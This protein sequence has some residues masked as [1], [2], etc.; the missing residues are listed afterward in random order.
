MNRGLPEDLN[1]AFP[2]IIPVT[3]PL[4]NN[5]IIQ[6]LNWLVGFVEGEGCFFVDI[7]KSNRYGVGSQ[8]QLKFSTGQHTRDIKLMNSLIN[9]LDCGRLA[10]HSKNPVVEYVV[11][12]LSDI[13]K[14]IIPLFDK[15][16][17]H[18]TKALNYKDFCK[19][20]DLIKNKAHLTASGLDQIGQ[21]KAGMN[22]RRNHL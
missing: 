21:I 17:L 16:P 11:T 15:Y 10:I 22:K 20:S 3:R 4:V 9:F 7:R 1:T 18:G 5:Q 8:V 2:K 6:D 14:I 13:D 12:K 19:V